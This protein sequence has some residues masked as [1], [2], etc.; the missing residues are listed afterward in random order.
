MSANA[1]LD[2]QQALTDKLVEYR[3]DPFKAVMFGFTWGEEELKPYAGPRKWQ[4]EVL[5]YI[6][7]H[8]ANPETRF[9]TCRVAISSGHGPGKWTLPLGGA[10]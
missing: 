4:R 8:F 2:W 5:D 6:G 9:K 3:H 10:A 1:T 7:E